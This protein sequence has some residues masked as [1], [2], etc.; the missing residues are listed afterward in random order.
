MDER[1]RRAWHEGYQM[2]NKSV[3]RQLDALIIK[4]MQI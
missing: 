3:K 1:V 4:E 2:A